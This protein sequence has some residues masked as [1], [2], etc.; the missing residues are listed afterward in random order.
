MPAAC[1]RARGGRA[2]HAARPLPSC[3]GCCVTATAATA[4]A[5]AGAAAP[6]WYIVHKRH[7]CVVDHRRPH[8]HLQA[9]AGVHTRWREAAMRRAAANW[10]AVHTQGP[11]GGAD[12]N[13]HIAPAPPACSKQGPGAEHAPRLHGSEE[14][15]RHCRYARLCRWWCKGCHWW[16]CCCC[17]LRI[18]E[19][20]SLQQQRLS[21][22][23]SA[24]AAQANTGRGRAVALLSRVLCCEPGARGCRDDVPPSNACHTPFLHPQDIP[25]RDQI[26]ASHL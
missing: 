1:A 7:R 11:G 15:L 9:G 17:C 4:P 22:T 18:M 6:T 2:G 19:R 3:T 16:W 21:V 13:T 5:R 25:W 12:S 24:A 8:N 23:G 20:R 10:H 26:T 14:V